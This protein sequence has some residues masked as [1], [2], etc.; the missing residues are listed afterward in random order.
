MESNWQHNSWVL[1]ATDIGESGG[2]RKYI[3][4]THSN[5]RRISVWHKANI[6]ILIKRAA[7]SVVSTSWWNVCNES[8]RCIIERSHILCL[9]LT[10]EWH[11]DFNCQENRQEVWMRIC[12]TV[13]TNQANRSVRKC[14]SLCFESYDCSLS[15]SIVYTFIYLITYLWRGPALGQT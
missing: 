11:V 15:V 5:L 6:I 13:L 8:W 14:F 10:S 7:Q 3:M 2:Q 4:K 9:A 12:E 1:K